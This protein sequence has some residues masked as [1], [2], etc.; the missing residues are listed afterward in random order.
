MDATGI[1]LAAVP[2]SGLLPGIGQ[3]A[4]TAS[5]A[6]MPFCCRYR[7]I[8][9]PLS[10]MAHAGIRKISVVSPYGD[11]ELMEHLGSGKDYGLALR[12]GGIRFLPPEGR[13]S[14]LPTRLALLKGIRSA[15]AED[16]EPLVV[17]SDGDCISAPD[18]ERML[19]EHRSMGEGVTVAVKRVYYG[20]KGQTPRRAMLC[21]TDATGSVTDWHAVMP[22]DHGS[23]TVLMHVYILPRVLLLTLIDEAIVHHLCG[24]HDCLMQICAGRYPIR[25]WYH[26]GFYAKLGSL[27]DY[28][29]ASMAIAKDPALH[30]ELF[31]SPGRPILTRVHNSPPTLY[32][33][34]ASAAGCLVADGCEI[35]VRAE[36]CL[37]FRGVR[38]GKGAIVR[39]SILLRG[40]QVA[41]C[42]RLD[43][44]VADGGTLLRGSL[45]GA[46]SYPFYVGAGTRL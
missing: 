36:N 14:G 37:L 11:R 9:F 27:A 35:E 6:A 40:T 44:V 19:Q 24:L 21:H 22:S 20:G 33:Q 12:S 41:P 45:S 13:I 46:P 15:I 4:E 17:L 38:I 28:F 34:G 10:A 26:E 31:A 42:S 3:R 23:V 29:A 32:R 18:L 25:V 2:R 30:Q 8:D 1:L 16:S 43:C 5:L 7:L 39:N